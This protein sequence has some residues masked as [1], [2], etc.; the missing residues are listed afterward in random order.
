MSE[1]LEEEEEEKEEEEEEEEEPRMTLQ[2]LSCTIS[3]G[4][5][6]EADLKGNENREAK[7]AT[8]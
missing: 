2:S 1:E 8:G 3:R 5:F 6:C 4:P 7:V